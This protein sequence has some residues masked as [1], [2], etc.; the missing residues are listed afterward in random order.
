MVCVYRA[1]TMILTYDEARARGNTQC[2][3]MCE[4]RGG[5]KVWD[6]YVRISRPR[7]LTKINIRLDFIRAT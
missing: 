6:L 2:D 3:S 5:E 7:Q 1:R 4:D